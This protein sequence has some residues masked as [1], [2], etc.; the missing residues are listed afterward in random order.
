LIS[1][2]VGGQ[3]RDLVHMESSRI[4]NALRYNEV[5]ILAF[6]DVEGTFVNTGF[7]SIR[8]AAKSWIIRKIVCPIIRSS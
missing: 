1:K 6:I 4:K 8:A 7:D 3:T 2:S 5:A